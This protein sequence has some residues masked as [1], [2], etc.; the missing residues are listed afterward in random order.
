MNTVGTPCRYISGTHSADYYLLLDERSDCI[1][2]T[3]LAEHTR[4][5]SGIGDERAGLATAT[6]FGRGWRSAMKVHRR[7]SSGFVQYHASL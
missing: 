1:L 5:A 4:E 2:A 6:E 7:A 3:R